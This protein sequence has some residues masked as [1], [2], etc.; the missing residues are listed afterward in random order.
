[1]RKLLAIALWLL[2]MTAGA[3][4][5]GIWSSGMNEADELKGSVA[6]PWYRYDVD[7]VGS[8]IN[9]APENHA[10]FSRVDEWR[11]VNKLK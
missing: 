2:C 7:G 10:V 3:Q 6:G 11:G 5:S 1:M 4:E 9:F 8:F